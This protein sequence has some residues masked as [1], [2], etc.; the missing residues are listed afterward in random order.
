MN[1]ISGKNVIIVVILSFFLDTLSGCSTPHKPTDTPP[2]R[3]HDE[4]NS[5]RTKTSPRNTVRY[6]IKKGDT[7]WKIA[8]GFGIS[9]DSIINSNNISD[10]T[11]ITPGDVLLIHTGI[12]GTKPSSYERTFTK[13]SDESFI[14]PLRGRILTNF[15]QWSDSGK[16]TGI[17]IKATNG[18]SVKASKGGIVALTSDTPDGWGKVIVLQHN[19]DSHTWYAHNSHIL[20]QKND[21]IKRGQVIAKAG[22]TGRAEQDKLHF[23]IFLNG[24][25]VNPSQHL[26]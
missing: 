10:V 25:P 4:L 19:D 23:K 16:S 5:L 21:V 8:H 12:Q 18:Q 2:L 13:E 22:S 15:N 9:P 20:V 26:Q 6:T 3:F 24:V 11:N 14:W 7:I 1:Y 17:D